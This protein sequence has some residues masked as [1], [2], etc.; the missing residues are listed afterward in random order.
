MTGYIVT[1]RL[2]EQGRF[3]QPAAPPATLNTYA[4]RH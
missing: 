4:G 1:A 3:R 2:I